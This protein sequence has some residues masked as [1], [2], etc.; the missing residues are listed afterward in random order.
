[1]EKEKKI[2]YTD[3]S[4]RYNPGPGG[5]A[6]VEMTKEKQI[7]YAYNQY[8]EFPVTNNQMEL[9]AMIFALKYTRKHS[10]YKYTIYYST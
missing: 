4:C 7:N 9:R 6:V 5:F 8:F 3:G 1:M 10:N 2:L